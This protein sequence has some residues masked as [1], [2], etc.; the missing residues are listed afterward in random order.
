M[1]GKNFQNQKMYMIFS[2][3][4]Y[5]YGKFRFIYDFENFEGLIECGT[6]HY[7]DNFFCLS[8]SVRSKYMTFCENG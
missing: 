1:T 3:N 7:V 2:N 6:K 5:F 4:L 8:I